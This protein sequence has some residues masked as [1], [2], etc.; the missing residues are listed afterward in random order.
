MARLPLFP[1]ATVLAPGSTL[2]LQVFEPRYRQLVTDL[3]DGPGAPE[4]GV[5]AIRAGSEVGAGAATRLADVG[6][7]AVLQHVD[8]LKPGL[9]HVK[10]RGSQRFRIEAILTDPAPY[11][12][13]DVTW[14]PEV[15]GDTRRIPALA[16]AVREQLEDYCDL[17][18]LP[19]PA[20]FDPVFRRDVDAA[21][22]LSY[23][24]GEHIVLPLDERLQLLE[25]ETTEE[26]LCLAR[27]LLTREMKLYDLLHA[28]PQR[29]DA[30]AISPY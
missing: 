4:F 9:Y 29:I 14:L 17:V 6:C 21:R 22:R 30:S 11:T 13:A 20:G 10:T 25:T 7:T 8:S 2:P 18:G 3:L 23:G 1:L 12:V 5:V 27:R 28:L 19:A 15:D 16:R 26:R 24:V